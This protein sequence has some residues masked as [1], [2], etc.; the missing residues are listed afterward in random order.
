MNN[1]SIT[2]HGLISYNVQVS[3]IHG[4]KRK[5][6]VMEEESFLQWH[7]MSGNF[8]VFVNVVS[9]NKERH[10]KAQNAFMDRHYYLLLFVIF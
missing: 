7:D 4:S 8:S 1:F 10:A 6:C 5:T 3:N 9:K 2:L